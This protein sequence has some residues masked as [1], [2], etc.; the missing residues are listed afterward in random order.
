LPKSPPPFR[1][2]LLTAGIAAAYFLFARVGLLFVT[3]PGRVAAIWPAA[4]F[5][6]AVLLLAGKGRRTAFAAAL[7]VANVAANITA[8]TPLP[9]AAGF[10]VAN[11]AEGLLA[12]WLLDRFAGPDIRFTRLRDLRV[13]LLMVVLAGNAVT[14][15][16]G[17][18]I[19]SVA[20]GADFPAACKSW[21]LADGCGMMLLTPFFIEWF[22]EGW[23]RVTRPDFRRLAEGSVAFTLLFA[24]F[25]LYV[26]PSEGIDRIHNSYMLLPF[27]IWIVVRLE[28]LGTVTV[29]LVF[30]GL[31]F[32][33]GVKG[34]DGGV[35]ALETIEQWQLLVSVT[36][37]SMMVLSAVFSER[38]QGFLS[39]RSLNES[40]ER[41]VSERTAVAE[42]KARRLAE[43]DQVQRA[44]V[45]GLTEANAELD[46]FSWSVSHDLR[47][48][49][50]ALREF[51]RALREDCG[52]RMGDKGLFHLDRMRDASVR[53]ES[54]IDGLMAVSRV[55]RAEMRRSP[56]NL[57]EIAREVAVELGERYPGRDVEFV[58][59]ERMDGH[60]DPRMMRQVYQN[61]LDNAWKFTGRRPDSRVE[62]GVDD[63]SG[64]PEYFVRD[65]G[66]GFDMEFADMLFAPFRRLH[67]EDD[68]PGTGIGLATVRRVVARHG[69]RIRVVSEV[70]RGTTFHFTLP[71]GDS[72]NVHNQEGPA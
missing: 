58:A 52:S 61:L 15:S 22:A 44:L 10:G 37:G 9:A 3:D 26:Y 68:F 24:A 11:A 56:L 28:T 36:T 66:A 72:M 41:Q 71:P 16:L 4:G 67:S 32:F 35:H 13:F 43:S 14:T 12:A 39:L 21:Y 54:V 60:G 51:G 62:V 1:E 18:A 2:I 46:A 33:F 48:P 57:S 6:L 29:N 25:F 70:G 30:A 7:F 53:M 49:L 40:L 64:S 19:A 65:N 45:A 17:A 47:A 69:G 42:D 27:L 38:R 50:R 63:S 8:G 20:L 5:Q 55:S 23:E 34:L 31:I 59:P